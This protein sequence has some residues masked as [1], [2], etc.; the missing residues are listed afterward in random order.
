MSIEN[1][2]HRESDAIQDINY[3]SSNTVL[4]NLDIASSLTE[5]KNTHEEG[6]CLH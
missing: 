5:G 1:E 4:L 2:G 6:M 3:E